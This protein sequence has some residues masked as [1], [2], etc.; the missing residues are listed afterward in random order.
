[1]KNFYRLQVALSV[2]PQTQKPIPLKQMKW[3]CNEIFKNSFFENYDVAQAWR[4]DFQ[5]HRLG[6][7]HIYRVRKVNFFERLWILATY[8]KRIIIR[9]F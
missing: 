7:T 2:D 3:E 9:D 1:M 4:I 8:K 6:K 5:A